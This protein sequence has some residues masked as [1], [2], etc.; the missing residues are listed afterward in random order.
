MFTPK[1][2]PF[3]GQGAAQA[4]RIDQACAADAEA[5]TALIG[6]LLDEI[7]TAVG[8]KAFSFDAEQS[9]PQLRRLIDRGRYVV[10]VAREHGERIVGVV[11]LSES[12]ALYAGGL[13]GTI[14]EFYVIPERRSLGIGALLLSA[15]RSHAQSQGWKR[16]EVTPPPLP[17][18]ER[19]LSFYER[20]GFSV[21]GGRKLKLE[22]QP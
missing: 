18:F 7:M 15:A 1:T 9:A 11:T 14:P 2:A 22:T 4:I 12:C 16:L 6:R 8:A 13:F 17:S 20:Q 21:T 3:K 10:F 19:A 5:I